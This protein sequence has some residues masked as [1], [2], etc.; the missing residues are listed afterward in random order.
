MSIEMKRY[1]YSYSQFL[2]DVKSLGSLLENRDFSAIIAVARGGLT[3]SHFLSNLLNIRSVYSINS[4]SYSGTTKLEDIHIFGLPHLQD[5]KSI[6]VVDDISDSGK[7][8]TKVVENLQ[9]LYPDTNFHTLTIFY[10]ST[11]SF[12]PNY[13]IHKIED[14]WIDFFWGTD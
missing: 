12:Q 3:I 9:H 13:Y 7:T 11:S 14:T 10:K 1:Y 2:K 4:I 5:E 8:L 6:L